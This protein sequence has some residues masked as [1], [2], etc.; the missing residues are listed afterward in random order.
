[1]GQTKYDAGEYE[2]TIRN[3]FSKN[4]RGWTVRSKPVLLQFLMILG[5]HSILTMTNVQVFGAFCW[6]LRCRVLLL[7]IILSVSF[8]LSTQLLCSHS[9]RHTWSNLFTMFDANKQV[10]LV[11]AWGQCVHKTDCFFPDKDCFL[12][13]WVNELL[14][15]L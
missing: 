8:Y 15:G 12:Y 5:K 3:R 7:V 13:E 1:M 11:F 2:C 14:F 9:D 10:V 6:S 4:R